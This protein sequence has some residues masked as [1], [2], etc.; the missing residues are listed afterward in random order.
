MK[1]LA[2]LRWSYIEQRLLVIHMELNFPYEDKSQSPT[3]IPLD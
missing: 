2:Y 3:N 1:H